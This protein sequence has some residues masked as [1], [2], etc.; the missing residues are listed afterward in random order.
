VNKTRISEVLGGDVESLRPITSKNFA[1]LFDS[2]TAVVNVALNQFS[3][4]LLWVPWPI[5]ILIFVVLAWRFGGRKVAF[6]SAFFLFAMGAFRLWQHGM[7]TLALVATAVLF[8]HCLG[9]T[10]YE[11][12][13]G[14]AA[15]ADM[16]VLLGVLGP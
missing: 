12:R 7:R 8:V 2:I 15:T 13:L 5:T 10:F 1:T 4:L 6:I 14:V 16:G 9:W 3:S 11:S